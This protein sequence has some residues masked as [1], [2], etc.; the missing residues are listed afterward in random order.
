VL[1]LRYYPD[2]LVTLP[3]SVPG[4]VNVSGG[5]VTSSV[6]CCDALDA[7]PLSAVIVNMNFFTVRAGTV[8]DKTP[9][10]GSIVSQRGWPESANIGRKARRGH[11]KA[12]EVKKSSDPAVSQT[13]IA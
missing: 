9:L 3:V 12:N 2:R 1:L 10:V 4:A 6:N 11:I 13:E 5:A 8:L 7:I